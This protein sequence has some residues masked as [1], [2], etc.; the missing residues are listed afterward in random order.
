MRRRNIVAGLTIAALLGGAFVALAQDRETEVTDPGPAHHAAMSDAPEGSCGAHFDGKLAEIAKTV[1]AAKK[2]ADP[3]AWADA[4][5][6]AVDRLLAA[7]GE[8]RPCRESGMSMDTSACPTMDA[9]DTDA[10]CPMYGHG[11][12]MMMGGGMHHAPLGG[13]CPSRSD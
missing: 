12:H 2:E 3:G 6:D 11:G 1:Q 9:S 5:L 8:S 13:S 10:D 4:A 7:F